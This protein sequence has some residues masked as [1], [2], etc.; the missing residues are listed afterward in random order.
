MNQPRLSIL[1]ATHDRLPLLTE[2]LASLETRRPDRRVYVVDA[3][4]TDGTVEFLRSRD[5]VV[6]VF[7]GRRLGSARAYNEVWR[8]VDSRYTVW[9]SDD[10]VVRPGMLDLA[11][12]LL[13]DDPGLGMVGLKMRDTAGPW[14]GEPYVGGISEFG[15]L[16]CNHGV[17]ATGLLRAVGFFNEGYRSYTIDADLTASVLCAG[18]RVAMTREVAVLHR[19][20]WAADGAAAAAA[21]MRAAQAGIDNAA[22]Y[23]AK[24]GFLGRPGPLS[25]LRSRV[26]GFLRRRLFRSGDAGE[27]RLGLNR[28]DWTNLSDARFVGPA[29]PLNAAG[30]PYHLVQRIPG[31]LLEHPDNPYR[32]LLGCTPP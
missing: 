26:G 27:V 3:G 11:V 9:L 28:R 2:A 13:E 5:D 15:V 32:H 22:V 1:V 16:T 10:T 23:R 19:R 12:G 25:R 18:R 24:F 20:E 4:S 21:H 6:A 7:Q 29:D 17:L 31:E 8:T 30:L 14:A